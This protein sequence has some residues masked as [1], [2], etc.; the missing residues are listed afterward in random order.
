MRRAP[1]ASCASILVWPTAHDPQPMAPG[2]GT[3]LAKPPYMQSWREM[4]EFRGVD[5]E[6]SQVL[7]WRFLDPPGRL[8]IELSARVISDHAGNSDRPTDRP[9]E[10]VF[11]TISRVDGLLPPFAFAELGDE[12]PRQHTLAYLCR[13]DDG[14]YSFDAS[15][16]II[17]VYCDDVHLR[18]ADE[19]RAAA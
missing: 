6:D 5:L 12:P 2:S 17:R 18:F 7:G 14:S 11:E 10:L 15:W 9:A 3:P 16:G 1:W 19:S 4:P 13:D 8:V